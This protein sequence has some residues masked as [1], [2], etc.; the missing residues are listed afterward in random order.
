MG[1]SNKQRKT[2]SLQIWTLIHFLFE[3]FDFNISIT[4]SDPWS[5]IVIYLFFNEEAFAQVEIWDTLQI[6]QVLLFSSIFYW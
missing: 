4:Y 6:V 1:L 2:Q 3:R 5:L